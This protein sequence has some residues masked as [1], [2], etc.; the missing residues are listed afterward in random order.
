MPARRRSS[1]WNSPTALPLPLP[2][3]LVPG[4]APFFATTFTLILLAM[5]PLQHLHGQI[6][7]DDVFLGVF[8]NAQNQI[9]VSVGR[10]GDQYLGTLTVQG[11]AYAF[12]GSKVMGMLSA[13]YPFQGQ[14]ASFS[15]SKIFGVYY[16]SADGITLEMARSSTAPPT[17][18][19]P[20]ANTGQRSN[21]PALNSSTS[22]PSATGSRLTDAANGYSFQLPSGFQ[23]AAQEGSYVV[24]KSGVAFQLSVTPHY[25]NDLQVIRQ[26]IADVDD[27][28]S[29]TQLRATT[30]PYGSNGLL[31]RL[32]GTAQGQPVVIEVITLLS[33]HGGGVAIAGAGSG[34]AYS[35]A[36][37][38]ALKTLANSVQFSKPQT[39][40]LAE[41][42]KQQLLN[43]KLTYLYTGNGFSEKKV[44]RLCSN[45]RFTFSSDD[46]YLSNDAYS[47]FSAAGS[48]G[49]QGSW[50]VVA[51]GNQ[52]ILRLQADQGTAKEYTLA[53]KASGE[54]Y[55]NQQR[56]FV[57]GGGCN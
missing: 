12:T 23:A 31:V 32:S 48:D 46:S 40:P 21:S 16:L 4:R 14:V 42:W 41:Q 30:A 3:F 33:P 5:A 19:A 26:E 28:A 47:N 15:L 39:S 27:P 6:S 10:Q 9:Q 34:G 11:Q 45:G 22:A 25:Y 51:R 54:I 38:S 8:N 55:L 49:S 52:A 50:K 2:G 43:K 37:T 57:E 29:N 18:S 24:T 13:T 53:P 17:P 1:I 7:A 35:A 56:Y 36:A 44:L 20:P